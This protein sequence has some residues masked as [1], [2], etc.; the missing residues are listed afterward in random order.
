MVVQQAALDSE[1]ERLFGNRERW[2]TVMKKPTVGAVGF[3]S[4]S[5]QLNPGSKRWL[6]D[7]GVLHVVSFHPHGPNRAR[8]SPDVMNAL[9]MSD[10][11]KSPLNVLSLASQ[12]W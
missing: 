3:S 11:W 6:S 10:F 9:T 8:Y 5:R 12:N 7:S 4:A 2:L 1:R